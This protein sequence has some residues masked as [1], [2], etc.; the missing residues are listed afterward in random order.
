ML[1]VDW[2]ESHRHRQI[3]FDAVAS[4]PMA[5]NR[6]KTSRGCWC[7]HSASVYR[8]RGPLRPARNPETH[9]KFLHLRRLHIELHHAVERVCTPLRQHHLGTIL[10]PSKCGWDVQVHPYAL[11]I[12]EVGVD[13]IVG[14]HLRQCARAAR[15]ALSVPVNLM[16]LKVVVRVIESPPV[17]L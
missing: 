13:A 2:F 7:L 6:C 8:N 9:R 16:S 14:C 4:I 3:H 1:W 5:M 17:G 10:C 11:R 12:A 15:P